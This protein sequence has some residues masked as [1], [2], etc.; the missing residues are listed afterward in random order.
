[1]VLR[2]VLELLNLAK[3]T[4][5]LDTEL[6]I[7]NSNSHNL[8]K[9]MV[10]PTEVLQPRMDLTIKLLRVNQLDYSHCLDQAQD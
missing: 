7:K 9:E 4:L 8:I 10:E 6:S 2:R 1:M 3:T 5:S